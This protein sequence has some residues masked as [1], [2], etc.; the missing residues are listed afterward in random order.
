[1]INL[2][3]TLTERSRTAGRTARQIHEHSDLI[4]AS[5]PQP[6]E[7]AIVVNQW[8]TLIGGQSHLYNRGAVARSLSGYYR[9]FSERNVPVDFLSAR[10]VTAAQLK[11]YKLVVVPYP[12]LLLTNEA[13]A[14]EQY[15]REGGRLFTEARPGWVDERGYAQAVVPGFGWDRML[16]VQEKSVTPKSETRVKWGSDEFAGA[17]FEERF[18]VLDPGAGVVAT[19]DDGSPAA[20]E[21]R[22]SQ[23]A[24]LI[25]GTFA[26][27]VNDS[28]PVSPHPLG[29]LLARWAGL[30]LPDLKA[31]SP[32][33]FKQLVAPAGR[34]LFLL[35]WSSSASKV[36]LNVP[37]DKPARQVRE[38]TSGQALPAG[39]AVFQL[40]EE[41]P[42][43][44]AR[45]YRIDY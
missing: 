32:V 14:L 43:Q 18:T 7:A 5:R 38:I 31:S 1:L 25:L 34:M 22:H 19:F 26:G 39:A 11:P 44:A 28:R 15:V 16:G 13:R 27:Q 37:L 45:V 3:G 36:E 20:Y 24:A 42:A 12:I 2:D 30:A 29:G 40:R 23:G 35:N 10:E 41:V 33:D 6:A 17:I 4:L 8:T 21:R 9:M